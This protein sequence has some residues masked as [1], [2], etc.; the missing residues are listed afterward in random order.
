MITILLATQN[1]YKIQEI[2]AVLPAGI[3]ASGID[4]VV[5]NEL[6]E[7]G[8]TLEENAL[9][10]ARKIYQLTGNSTLSDDSGL[11]VAALDN[12]PGVYSARYAGPQKDDQANNAKLLQE[13]RF[14][15]IRHARFRTVLAF[16]DQTGEYLFEGIVNGV[17]A[18][19]LRGSNG[20]GYDP[21]FIPEG[22]TR[23]FAQ[24]TAEEKNRLSHR[25]K[26]VMAWAQWMASST[27]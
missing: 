24:M 6:E 22:E 21:L 10:K 2:Q 26:A 14:E 1:P 16:I 20:F 8:F 27:S 4:E 25:S 9:Q 19:E 7:T 3:K 12:A 5:K 15:V 13:L 11:E 17:I 18:S 23:T